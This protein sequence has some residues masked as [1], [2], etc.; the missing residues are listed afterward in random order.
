MNFPQYLDGYCKPTGSRFCG[1]LPVPRTARILCGSQKI[2]TLASIP[3]YPIPNNRLVVKNFFLFRSPPLRCSVVGRARLQVA[4]IAHSR[5]SSSHWRRLQLKLNCAVAT[6]RA[7]LLCS[8]RA[9]TYTVGRCW[10]YGMWWRW[11]R[12][13]LFFSHARLTHDSSS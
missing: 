2:L 8:H 1:C 4:R 10:C 11:R 5:V 3:P 13:R 6:R 7:R 9:F 12:R